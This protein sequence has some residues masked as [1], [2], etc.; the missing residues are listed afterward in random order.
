MLSNCVCL[1]LV[2]GPRKPIWIDVCV[3]AAAAIAT[4]LGIR[5]KVKGKSIEVIA[6]IVT[7]PSPTSELL[8]R[9]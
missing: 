3:E 2:L 4:L 6:I 1:D 7:T 8:V 9:L 5:V